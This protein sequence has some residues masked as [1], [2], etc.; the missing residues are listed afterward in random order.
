MF[1]YIHVFVHSPRLQDSDLWR[2]P[3]A[4]P[5]DSRRKHAAGVIFRTPHKI[6]VIKACIK[7]FSPTH[8]VVAFDGPPAPRHRSGR[9]HAV[10]APAS[11]RCCCCPPI[12]P[13]RLWEE[14]RAR[15]CS[16]PTD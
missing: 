9:V 2:P 5:G 12:L 6:V 15:G 8:V 16:E 7:V 3:D 11:A 1:R 13:S 14:A 10:T 4:A